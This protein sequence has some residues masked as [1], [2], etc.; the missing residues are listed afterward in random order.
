M[1]KQATKEK[2]KHVYD[3][4]KHQ[5]R[6]EFLNILQ[7]FR[8]TTNMFVIDRNYKV[9]EC[10]NRTKKTVEELY[11]DLN[12]SNITVPPINISADDSNVP[13]VTPDEIICLFKDM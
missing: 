4:R 8:Q 5:K 10:N 3:R 9:I 13:E 1:K 11:K 2:E 12:S 7:N 6:E